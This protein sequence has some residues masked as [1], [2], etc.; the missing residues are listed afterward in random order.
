MMD[1]HATVVTLEG[2]VSPAVGTGRANTM[3]LGWR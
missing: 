1:L 3:G 2:A